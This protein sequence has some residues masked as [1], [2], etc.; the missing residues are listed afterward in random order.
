MTNQ[1][2]FGME[3]HM[4]ADEVKKI[5]DAPLKEEW[6]KKRKQGNTQLS[7]IGGHTVIRLL[8][9]AFQ[10]AWSFEIIN[11]EIVESL[12]KPDVEWKN[13]R[14]VQK[15]DS[16]GVG[17]TI[18]QPPV[19]KVLGRLS[20]PG[21][22]V[23]EQ[24]GSKVL[25]GG[26]TEQE[27][28]FKSASTDAM[29]KCASLFGIGL[30]L[31]GDEGVEDE[32]AP[33]SQPA[34]QQV[35]PQTEQ[36]P[37]QAQ[38]QPVP[39]QQPAPQTQNQGAQTSSGQAAGWQKADT[40]RLKDLKQILAIEDNSGLDIYAQEFFGNQEASY[41]NISPKNIAAFNVFLTGKAENI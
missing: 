41:R 37:Q 24:Y 14:R 16:N 21:Y 30:E 27:S 2:I 15:V 20:V 33:V 6:I 11:E 12:P 34:V 13:N 36:A 8:N 4:P 40:D 7:Y 38:A 3:R 39:A 35:Q 5:V 10:Y 32:A 28:A 19:V 26:A 23:K 17:M 29:K 18:P 9:R 1:D 25:I 31:W 22:G